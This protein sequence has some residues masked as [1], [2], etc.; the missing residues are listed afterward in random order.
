[1]S[2]LVNKTAVREFVKE[3]LNIRPSEAMMERIDKRIKEILHQARDR[4]DEAG[5][6]TIKARHI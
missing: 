2:N 6:L 1:M 5:L 4:A 3:E